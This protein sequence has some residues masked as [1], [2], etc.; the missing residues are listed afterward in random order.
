MRLRRRRRQHLNLHLHLNLCQRPRGLFP[1]H[2]VGMRQQTVQQGLDALHLF[3]SQA[4]GGQGIARRQGQVAQPTGMADAADRA[5]LGAAQKLGFVPGQQLSHRRAGQAGSGIKVGQGAA[6]GVF[7]PGADQLAFVAAVDPVA[8]QGAQ[9]FRDRARVL[10]GQVR[11]TTPRIQLLRPDDRCCGA[12]VDTG[13]ALTAM[14]AQR[15]ARRQGKVHKQFAQKKHRPGFALQHQGVFA[16]PAQA[17]AGGQFSLQHGRRI[18]EHAVAKRT[19]GLR[20]LRLEFL[21]PA[22]QHLVV[23]PP[24]RIQRNHRLARS[25]GAGV[26]LRHPIAIGVPGQII[27]LGGDH[28]HRA[29][30]QLGG[31]GALQAV[32][33]HVVHAAVETGRQP[34]L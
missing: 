16:A 8:D 17:A 21:Q 4:L 18:G 1:H 27:H 6:L 22:A 11:N 30:H 24:P 15:F 34:G 32:G 29:G 2:R 12:Q 19:D 9:F 5:A 33:G 13:G 23:V 28:T 7:V 20:D 26:F 25:L 31:A 3:R 14:G 10:D